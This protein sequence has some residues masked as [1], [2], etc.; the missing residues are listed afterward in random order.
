[1][2]IAQD[3]A[4]SVIHGMPREAVMLGAATHVLPIGDIGSRLAALQRVKM[5]AGQ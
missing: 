3:E 1:M 5:E 2:T 4:T